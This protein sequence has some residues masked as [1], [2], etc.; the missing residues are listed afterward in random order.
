MISITETIE[1]RVIFRMASKP[2]EFELSKHYKGVATLKFYPKAHYYVVDDPEY[3]DPKTGKIKPLVKQQLG[4]ATSLTGVMDKGMGLMLYPMYESSKF[5]RN[6]FATTTV[7]EMIDNPE[8]VNDLLKLANSAHTNKSDR[9]K[10]VGTDAHAWV[11]L[12]LE[13][14]RDWQEKV[15]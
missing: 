15:W 8:T 1:E 12:Y 11:Q 3:V 7:K 13:A 5:L 10:S 4:G 9:G 14:L 2:A 6:Y